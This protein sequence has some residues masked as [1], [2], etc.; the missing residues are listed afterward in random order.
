M[1]VRPVDHG[2]DGEDFFAAHQ[3]ISVHGNSFVGGFIQQTEN[4]CQLSG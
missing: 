4:L 2:R 3:R 1:A